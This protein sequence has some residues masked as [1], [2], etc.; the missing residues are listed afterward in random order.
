[1]NGA[2]SLPEVLT[3]IAEGSYAPFEQHGD[4]DGGEE[5]S[6]VSDEE[7]LDMIVQ[8]ARLAMEQDEET[9]DLNK[10]SDEDSDINA[11]E[12]S[13]NGSD[14]DYITRE[15]RG[16]HICTGV[17]CGHARVSSS[18]KTFTCK[19][20]TKDKCEWSKRKKKNLSYEFCPLPHW[21][22]ILH[23]L[24]KHFCLHPLLPEHH[25]QP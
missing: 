13:D 15:I 14:S 17:S 19:Q 18:S 6:D 23:L 2:L 1:M 22:S 25:G 9:E 3:G 10:D 5:L 7:E 8:V 20:V 4:I 12:G 11:E 24:T 21:P 16:P